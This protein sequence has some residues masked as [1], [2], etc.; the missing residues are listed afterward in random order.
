[1]CIAFGVLDRAGS[2]ATAVDRD[3]G[4]AGRCPACGRAGLPRLGAYRLRH[5]L[6][7]DLLRAG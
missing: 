2:S 4:P 5:T 3:G 6:A 1:M 7:S